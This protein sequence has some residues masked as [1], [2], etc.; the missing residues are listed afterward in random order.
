[1]VSDVYTMG[2]QDQAFLGP[3]SGLAIPGEDG[4]VDLFLATQ[5]LHV[6]QKQTARALGLPLDKVRFTMSGV[7][8]AFG[9]REDLSMQIHCCMLA[10]HTGKPVKMVYNRLESFYGHVH[11]H[12]AKMYYE[13][14]ATKDGKLV[15]VKA[16]MYFDGGAYA[17]K[18]PVVVSNA[19][20]LGTGPY[21]VPNVR[22]E[23]WG[24]YTNNPPCGAMRGLGAVQPAFAY[25][26]QMDKLAGALGMDPVRLRQINAVRE[27]ASLHTG[28]VLDS[29]PRSP[30]SWNAWRGCRFRRR[31]PP[32]PGTSAR[33]P[34]VSPTPRTARASSGVSVT[35]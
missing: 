7:G 30:S 12:P 29:P 11:R 32:R 1:M 31:T 19:T 5:W 35:A 34:A 24:V 20:S 18:T 23:G 10:L 26:L 21:V 27:G 6:D 33:C 28:Q 2:M 8:G 13:H 4:G 25:E 14:G 16:R 9:G 15:Y 3:E 17:S 22:I